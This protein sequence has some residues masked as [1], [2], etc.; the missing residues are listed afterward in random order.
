L[1]E[2]GPVAERVVAQNGQELHDLQK[3]TVVLQAGLS[4]LQTGGEPGDIVE[5]TGRKERERIAS[6]MEGEIKDYAAAVAE[7]LWEAMRPALQ[8][9]PED[10][11]P[12]EV[13]VT[14]TDSQAFG[15]HELKVDLRKKFGPVLRRVMGGHTQTAVAVWTADKV[16]QAYLFKGNE[17]SRY[18]QEMKKAGKRDAEVHGQVT[19]YCFDDTEAIAVQHQSVLKNLE[20]GG[21][22]QDQKILSTRFFK[23]GGDKAKSISQG[24]DFLLSST[25]Q[26]EGVIPPPGEFPQRRRLTELIKKACSQISGE[27]LEDMASSPQ[28]RLPYSGETCSRLLAGIVLHCALNLN[29]E[30]AF[31][32]LDPFFY[33]EVDEPDHRREK[34][35]TK[36]LDPIRAAVK[37]EIAKSSL[38]TERVTQSPAVV[39]AQ[40]ARTAFE[41]AQT[42]SAGAVQT[43]SGQ[44]KTTQEKEVSLQ[45]DLDQWR[46]F[47]ESHL[48]LTQMPRYG[49]TSRRIAEEWLAQAV[50][51]VTNRDKEGVLAGLER[52]TE[53][54][55]KLGD[56]LTPNAVF[57]LLVLGNSRF[58]SPPY[59]GI[60]EEYQRALEEK[61]NPPGPDDDFLEQ[62][63]DIFMQA[64]LPA[65]IF[66]RPPDGETIAMTEKII[67]APQVLK[68]KVP[69]KLLDA[70][71]Q[72]MITVLQS[73]VPSDVSVN[74]LPQNQTFP[75]KARKGEYVLAIATDGKN[76]SLS[77]SPR[78]W[79]EAETRVTA[80]MM[81]SQLASPQ[82]YSFSL[83][84]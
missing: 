9:E 23:E 62:V 64:T 42:D 68:G 27:R 28:E 5:T 61:A 4:V 56:E 63:D 65:V 50:S 55:G 44:L 73:A 43:L 7:N 48:P 3:K 59:R 36:V 18:L 26:L 8:Y 45:A 46:E 34:L 15:H 53:K 58:I 78:N 81:L 14:L 20:A 10:L 17:A 38:L 47:E 66:N 35:V 54:E 84:S 83:H 71:G 51:Q 40:E 72:K 33:P 19:R 39:G 22:S 41:Q 79:T 11:L 75:I 60:A 37:S 12:R 69:E 57:N 74:E 32:V 80:P 16:M 82:V 21:V 76:G 25:L 31:Q 1:M 77:E 6:E 24:F 49:E 29:D 13:G 2:L 30:E 70:A 52:Q 67:G